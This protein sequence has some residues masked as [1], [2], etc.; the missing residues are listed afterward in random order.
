MVSITASRRRR[1]EDRQNVRQPRGRSLTVALSSLVTIALFVCYCVGDIT[2]TLPGPLTLSPVNEPT[3]AHPVTAKTGGTIAGDVDL[4]RAIDAS[5]ASSLVDE[6]LATEG[7]GS[8]VSVVIE[9][10]Q[11]KVAAEHKAD[12]TREPAST[13]KTLTALAAASTLNMASTLDTQVFLTQTDDGTNTLTI[14]G[15]GDMLLSAGQSDPDHINGRAGLATLAQA[16]VAALAQRGIT[17]VSLAYDDTLFGDTRVPSGLRGSGDVVMDDYTMY[18]TPVSSMAV[19][20]GRQYSDDMPAPADPDDS[21]GYPELSQT[22]ASDTAAMFASLLADNG[23]AV[24]GHVAAGEAPDEATPVASVSSATLSEIMAYT[25]R[26]SDNTLAEEFGRLLALHQDTGNNP[27]GA[28]TA[29]KSVLDKLGI[30]TDGLTM[31]DCSGLSP[32]SLLS[33]R[34]LVAVQ[35]RNLTA[36]PGGAAA[37][38]L[39]IAGLIGTAQNRYT[40]ESVAG[41][42]RVKT[43][44]LG[45]VTSMAGNVSRT[46]G[47]VLAFAVIV[48]NPDDMAAVRAAIDSFI[49]KLAGL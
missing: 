6:L 33:V 8:D 39:S 17:T 42:L 27:E 4:T 3:F 16:T 41:L 20:E 11:G 19:D 49:T 18:A 26:H 47:G 22:T 43:G 34:T 37:E 30:P 35:Q 14:K 1:R 12:T 38:G 13:M 44:S 36:G 21:A 32:G 2:D 28:A 46:D 5:A 7:I 45:T 29:V 24:N 48:N 10:G 9:D 15:N 25:L 23:I 40:D 31:A